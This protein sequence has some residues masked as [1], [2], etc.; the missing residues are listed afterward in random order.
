MILNRPFHKPI[1]Q[2][3][4]Q[5]LNPE[6]RHLQ[7]KVPARRLSRPRNREIRGRSAAYRP[8]PTTQP[9]KEL[10]D[11]YSLESSPEPTLWG[12]QRASEPPA[13]EQLCGPK[14]NSQAG[15]GPRA[16]FAVS[17]TR[18]SGRG[19]KTLRLREFFMQMENSRELSGESYIEKYFGEKLCNPARFMRPAEIFCLID[20]NGLRRGL[21]IN[22]SSRYFYGFG[23]FCE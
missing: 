2:Q 19:G 7:V 6:H 12:K 8:W 14:E 11:R 3:Q 10:V 4:Q 23:N 16:L 13:A 9:G 1:N 21:V 18:T 20:F 5:R 15:A 22:F 17:K